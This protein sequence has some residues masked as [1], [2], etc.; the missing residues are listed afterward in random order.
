MYFKDI[1]KIYI[2]IPINLPFLFIHP[3]TLFFHL[4]FFPF[5]LKNFSISLNADLLMTNFLSFLFIWR[6]F[7]FIFILEEY[8]CWKSN[9]E[10]MIFPSSVLKKLFHCFLVCAGFDEKAVTL[11]MW[12]CDCD[13]FFFS[14]CLQDFLFIFSFQQ[15]DF[16]GPMCALLFIFSSA[17]NLLNFLNLKTD[18]FFNSWEISSHYFFKYFFCLILFSPSRTP[19]THILERV[20]YIIPQFLNFFYSFKKIPS[21]VLQIE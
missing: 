13:A 2:L 7:H 4:D 11:K 19:R 8:F 1:K 17:L 18:A 21:S 12:F 15:C 5:S 10:L 16:D 3:V 9:P 20:F 14:G 6:C